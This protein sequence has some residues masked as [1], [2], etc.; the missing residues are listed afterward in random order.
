M[1]GVNNVSKLKINDERNMYHALEILNLFLEKKE[2]P[3]SFLVAHNS[4]T[5]DVILIKYVEY[6]NCKG[7]VERYILSTGTSLRMGAELTKIHTLLLNI[8]L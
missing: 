7:F 5:F 3:Y 1:K 6:P 8:I 4:S 2:R